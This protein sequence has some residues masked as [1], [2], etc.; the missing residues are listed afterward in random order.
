VFGISVVLVLGVTDIDDKII[1]R[2]KTLGQSP[3]QLA[4]H[5]EG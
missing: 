4:K 3:R 2:A 5:Y 1:N